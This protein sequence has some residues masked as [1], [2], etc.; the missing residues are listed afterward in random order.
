MRYDVKYG[1]DVS[2]NNGPIDWEDVA[3]AGVEFAMIRTGYGVETEDSRFRENVQG[4]HDAGLICG[5]Y[6]YSYAL[7]P[8]RAVQEARFCRETID[9][10]GCLLELPVFFDME[11]A[12]Q[13]KIDKG[14]EFSRENV[15]AICREFLQHIR[16]NCGVYASKS[17]LDKW[18]DW[19]SLGCSVWSAEWMN[20]WNP[21]PDT[22]EDSFGGYMWQYTNKKII[23]GDHFDGDILYVPIED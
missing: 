6:H 15:T 9:K 11:D 23:A 18:I 20:G 21:T 1:I 19:Q 13:Y 12:D 17:W 2:E 5:A 7:N 22:N 4:A 10:A 8:Q 16:L 14:F 3:A